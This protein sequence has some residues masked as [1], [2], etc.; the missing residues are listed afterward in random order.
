[1]SQSSVQ[2]ERNDPATL[3]PSFS[4]VTSEAMGEAVSFFQASLRP[5]YSKQYIDTNGWC[6]NEFHSV[7]TVTFKVGTINISMQLRVQIF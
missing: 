5:F 3:R 1:M 6:F 4:L 7:V 2:V